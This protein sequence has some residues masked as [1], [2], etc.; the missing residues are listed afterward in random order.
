MWVFILTLHNVLILIKS[1]L[2]K[3]QNLYLASLHQ[4]TKNN[5]KNVF[6]STIMLRFGET[7]VAK[8]KLYG[9]KKRTNIRDVNFHNVVSS[10][11]V[12]TRTN[13]KYLIRFLEKVIRPIV[14]PKMSGYVKVFK[15]KDGDKDKNKLMSFC[16]NDEKLLEKI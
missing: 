8:E 11:L 16:I 5:D 15:F 2:N 4:L 6:E 7:K 9:G 13:S 3:D 14:L 1:V 10:K 12:E